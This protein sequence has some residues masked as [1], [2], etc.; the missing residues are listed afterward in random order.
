MNINHFHQLI[1]KNMN[2]V[3]LRAQTKTIIRVAKLII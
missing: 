2:E 3:I 1:N